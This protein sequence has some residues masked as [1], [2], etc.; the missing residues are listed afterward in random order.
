[1]PAPVVGARMPSRIITVGTTTLTL[2]LN[3]GSQRYEGFTENGRI[4]IRQEPWGAW[5]ACIVKRNSK[6]AMISVHGDYYTPLEAGHA[7][8]EEIHRFE[9]ALDE[10]TGKKNS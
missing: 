2:G 1:M 10:F 9:K 7:L 3:N 6:G 5:S 8:I 4:L